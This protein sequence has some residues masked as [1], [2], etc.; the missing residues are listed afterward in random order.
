MATSGARNAT[1][2]AILISSSPHLGSLL[3]GMP[4]NS[5]DT[6]EQ[7]LEPDVLDGLLMLG[8]VRNDHEKRPIPGRPPIRK[9]TPSFRKAPHTESVHHREEII[10]EVAA[11]RKASRPGSAPGRRGSVTAQP[12]ASSSGSTPPV[13]DDTT[14]SARPAPAPSSAEDMA[15]AEPPLTAT[16][17]PAVDRDGED[18]VDD[19]STSSSSFSAALEATTT[20]QTEEVLAPSPAAR[21]RVLGEVFVEA[22]QSVDAAAEETLKI[23]RMCELVTDST[24]L[25]MRRTVL[26]LVED[27]GMD[28]DGEWQAMRAQHL[29]ANARRMQ[30]VEEERRQAPTVEHHLEAEALDE[31]EAEAAGAAEPPPEQPDLGKALQDGELEKDVETAMIDKPFV[32]KI[33]VMCDELVGLAHSAKMGMRERRRPLGGVVEARQLFGLP[34]ALRPK[35]EKELAAIAKA[36]QIAEKLAKREAEEARRRAPDADEHLGAPKPKE[37]ILSFRNERNKV[38]AL[39]GLDGSGGGAGGGAVAGARSIRR[40]LIGGQPAPWRKKFAGNPAWKEERELHRSQSVPLWLSGKGRL[41]WM[42]RHQLEFYE[43]DAPPQVGAFPS[44]GLT[45]PAPTAHAPRATAGSSSGGTSGAPSPAR[46]PQSASQATSIGS[47]R[48][49]PATKANM[50]AA[51]AGFA[52]NPVANGCVVNSLVQRRRPSSAASNPMA[53]AA[54]DRLHASSPAPAYSDEAL[55]HTLSK[56]LSAAENKLK[57]ER[58]AVH[59][60]FVATSVAG[61]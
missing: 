13:A 24:R 16:V 32:T 11:G 25:L 17:A 8:S 6:V 18:E 35:N 48:A 41:Q 15:D 50:L 38:I 55:Q 7:D 12:S 51:A 42:A 61:R 49:E 56:G 45:I 59:R 58:L 47:M 21:W 52:V 20:E 54:S 57:Q 2:N 4:A 9:P 60:E 23:A 26:G 39:R 29:Q 27:V 5:A 40:N 30:S 22:P 31:A 53:S 37:E 19:A 14:P 1:E 36:E 44:P 3:Y 28:W 10:A 46:R 43:L 33:R 34:N